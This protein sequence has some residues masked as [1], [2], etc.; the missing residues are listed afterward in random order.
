MFIWNI[1][2]NL[3]ACKDN[4]NNDSKLYLTMAKTE[5]QDFRLIAASK[6]NTVGSIG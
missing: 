6:L 4:D 1:P 5:T 3:R 2:T